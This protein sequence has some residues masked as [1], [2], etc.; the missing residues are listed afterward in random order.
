[1][2]SGCNCLNRFSR[3]ADKAVYIGYFII[4]VTDKSCIKCRGHARGD[5]SN[6]K[7]FWFHLYFRFHGLALADRIICL[8]ICRVFGLE[9]ILT[10]QFQIN[11]GMIGICPIHFIC[12]HIIT[13]LDLFG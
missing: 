9:V 11:R 2:A 4:M 13:L 8:A 6:N 12:Q 7:Q 3:P 10:K 1:M 5:F